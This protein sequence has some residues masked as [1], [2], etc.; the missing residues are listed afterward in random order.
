[1]AHDM[2][3]R[4]I[5]RKLFSKILACASQYGVVHPSVH[6]WTVRKGLPNCVDGVTEMID[7]DCAVSCSHRH[8]L[9][10]RRQIGAHAIVAT[11]FLPLPH[12][13]K[14]PTHLC[15]AAIEQCKSREE[16][17]LVFRQR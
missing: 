10:Y 13:A 2:S 4:L 7:R 12:H 11:V 17:C 3:Y 16:M 8:P 5:S 14:Y 15:F 1:M 6:G 9:D